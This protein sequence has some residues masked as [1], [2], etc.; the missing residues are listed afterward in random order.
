MRE[1]INQ[2]LG[3]KAMALLVCIS[4][5]VFG[6]LFVV[7][8]TW[9]RRLTIDSLEKGQR[10][11]AATMK[12]ALDGA[13]ALGDRDAMTAFFR[14]A[15][16]LNKDLTIHL[17]VPGDRISFST[18]KEGL[19]ASAKGLF[20]DPDLQ[21]D[22]AASM[23]GPMD[24]GRIAQV[25]GI[26]TYVYLKSFRNEARCAACHGQEPAYLGTMVLLQDLSPEWRAMGI[27]G[28]VLGA[29]SLA[30]MGAL[31]FVMLL[32]IR[33][34]VSGPLE[35]F[36]GVLEEVASGDLRR[37][38]DAAAADEVGN[39]GRSLV[40]SMAGLRSTLS[41]VR[42]SERKVQASSKAITEISEEM[43]RDTR[44]ASEKAGSVAAAAEEM[45]A[46]A[47]SVASAM[48][49]AVANLA[50]I[51]D[52]TAQMTSTIHEIAGNSERARHI[53]EKASMHADGM[54]KVMDSLGAAAG[55][56]GQVTETIGRISSQTNLLALNATIEAAR[57]GTAGK[58]FAVVAGEI[59]AL[60]QQTTAATEDIQARIDAIQASTAGA[61]ADIHSI[62]DVIREVRDVVAVIASAIEEQSISTRN[63][64]ENL[65]QAS[66]E[67]LG[68]SSGVV[69]TASVSHGIA[70][71]I[72]Q[73]NEAARHIN[74]STRESRARSIEL[75]VMAEQLGMVLASFQFDEAGGARAGAANFGG[76]ADAHLNWKARLSQAAAGILKETL[77]PS[78]ISRDDVC[79]M[80]RWIHGA[81]RSLE[82]HPLYPDLVRQHAA[83]H[84]CAGKVAALCAGN[85][86]AAAEALLRGDQYQ[87]L[88]R[89]VVALL[90]EM[91]LSS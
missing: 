86:L 43:S 75:G 88:T 20:Q 21:G 9:Q 91:E 30:G 53:T 22:L 45:S 2:S 70:R 25:G 3:R 73:V 79:E 47:A 18:R 36:G 71:D 8:K 10:Q 57:A 84:Q 38:P 54:R 72:A 81:G 62:T 44:E 39:L 87:E 65:S 23:T 42:R 32:F 12:L 13:M 48:D 41:A 90:R 33:R 16:E 63:I 26:P 40:K 7:T 58:G 34:G 4:V 67:V 80:G 37:T 17:V 85:Q 50:R 15:G 31:V 6:T 14:G 24:G 1:W 64:A 61:I 60:A 82:G 27:Q 77:D 56:I 5:L 59:K 68:A 74:D 29:L 83:F 66:G 51:S 35:A 52:A 11:E 78:A 49:Q 89:S 69:Q 76:F 55:E 28:W 19:P 46:S